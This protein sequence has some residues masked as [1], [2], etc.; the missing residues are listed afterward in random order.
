MKGSKNCRRMVYLEALDIPK[1]HNTPLRCV[2][3]FFDID[4]FK[5]LKKGLHKYYKGS[6]RL[7]LIL[8]MK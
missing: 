5:T 1:I 7:M 6:S 2:R 3:F 8:K 4:G